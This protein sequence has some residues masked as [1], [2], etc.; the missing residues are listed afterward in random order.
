MEWSAEIQ[1]IYYSNRWEYRP[2]SRV[3]CQSVLRAIESSQFFKVFGYTQYLILKEKVLN[4]ANCIGYY[5][6]KTENQKTHLRNINTVAKVCY[7]FTNP[8]IEVV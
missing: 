8:F 7:L 4:P 2:F 5:F 1:P 3:L 6:W